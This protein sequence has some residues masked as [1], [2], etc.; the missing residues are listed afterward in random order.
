M[1]A[2]VL[3]KAFENSP[4]RY[5]R[6]MRFL[7]L[8]RIDRL[9]DDLARAV[10]GEGPRVLELGCGPGALAVR[11]A[12]GGARVLGIDASDAM[13]A[14]ARKRV[15]AAGLS[16]RVELR[17]MSVM[18][19]DALPERSFDFVVSTLVLSELSD[20]EVAFVLGASRRLLAPGGSLLIGDEAE[21]SGRLRRFGFALLRYPLQLL[22]YLITQAQSLPRVGPART[23]LYFAV[24][25]PLMLLVFLVVPPTSR[26]LR[27]VHRSL[28]R[29]GFRETRVTDY[30]GG[31]LK[32]VH[33]ATA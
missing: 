5:D 11:M 8:G 20:D 2:Y 23:L 24:E 27:D 1:P 29:A 4:A 19:I 14:T 26:P 7:T 31:T 15:E 3:M 33:A 18:E 17:R 25:L 16:D 9:K 28:L 30:L 21:P 10:T 22:T 12:Q 6:A 32:L 13:L